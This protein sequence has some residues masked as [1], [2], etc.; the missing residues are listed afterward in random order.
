MQNSNLKGIGFNSPNIIISHI[1]KSIFN[2]F[3]YNG[4][5]LPLFVP[6][7]EKCERGK[8]NIV[9]IKSIYEFKLLQDIKNIHCFLIFE[10]LSTLEK[11]ADI[12]LL[13]AKNTKYGWQKKVISCKNLNKK[14]SDVSYT[15]P[16]IT[17]VDVKAITK[18]ETYVTFKE[19]CNNI[20]K[21]V[22]K[23]EK[24]ESVPYYK[25]QLCKYAINE[26]PIKEWAQIMDNLIKKGVPKLTII[27]LIKYVKEIAK[28]HKMYAEYKK[29][30]K[31][32]IAF[33]PSGKISF[34]NDLCYILSIIE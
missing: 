3:I 6:L 25:H 28:S 20:L 23:T 24:E 7:I 31:E 2:I 26:L 32:L 11:I 8:K 29:S 5:V 10:D 33:T 18:V 30:K 21:Y 12:T 13:D 16:T 34:K 17:N 4:E 1:D 9:V 14:L 27:E 15:L 22:E 19:L